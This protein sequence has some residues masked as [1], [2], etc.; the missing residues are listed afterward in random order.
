MR[1]RSAFATIVFVALGASSCNTA[2]ISCVAPQ[3]A[4]CSERGDQCYCSDERGLDPHSFATVSRSVRADVQLTES[5][6]TVQYARGAAPRARL[7]LGGVKA[8]L[9]G[10]NGALLGLELFFGTGASAVL[11]LARMPSPHQPALEFVPLRAGQP[12][13]ADRYDVGVSIGPAS[14]STVMTRPLADFAASMQLDSLRFN[15][16]DREIG[17][18]LS[19]MV[20]GVDSNGL[21]V[22]LE[23][24][25]TVAGVLR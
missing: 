6:S 17:F 2:P 8:Y 3:M 7:P 13:A 12:L 1:M 19:V 20:D 21:S 14:G 15:A 5:A 22:Q 4:F 25:A 16:V 18:T 11:L 9:D 24:S 10:T 23:G